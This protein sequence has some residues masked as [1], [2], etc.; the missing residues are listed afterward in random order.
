MLPSIAGFAVLGASLTDVNPGLTFWTIVTFLVVFVFLRWK[1]WGPILDMV[2]EREK[3]IQTAL[4]AAK[5]EREQ[6]Q[7]VLEEQKQVAAAARLE[8]LEAM[9]RG[10]ADAERMRQ[11][12]LAK[13]RQEAEELIATAMRQI[14]EEKTKAIAEVRS[15]TVDLA[16]MAA[17]KLV[18]S[19]LDESHQRELVDDF[20]RKL[21]SEKL[22]A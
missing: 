3:A 1:A 15:H 4:D 19:S 2:R 9:K 20:I 12:L 6:A 14:E 21:E 13:S 7:K 11:E 10:Q 8:S 18:E 22:S 17:R 5:V 16:V